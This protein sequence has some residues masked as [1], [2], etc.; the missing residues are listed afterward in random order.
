MTTEYLKNSGETTMLSK[1]ITNLFLSTRELLVN[2][3]LSLT[4]VHAEK[5][6]REGASSVL[7]ADLLAE[8]HLVPELCKL[9][10]GVPVLCEE[11][12]N[13]GLAKLAPDVTLL[14][15]SDNVNTLPQDAISVDGLDGS[16][17]Y[18]NG[19]LSL[20]AMSAGLIKD[21]QPHAGIIMM[22]DEGVLYHT[23]IN[24]TIGVFRADQSHESWREP[25]RP[26]KQ[27]LI[28]L[29]DNKAVE[30]TFRQFVVN[31][32][33]GSAGTQYPLNVPSVAGGIK[34]LQGKLAVY[35]TSNARHWDIAGTA[36]LCEGAGMV[37]RCL[38]GSPVPWN[39]VQMPPVVFARDEEAF[40][41]VHEQAAE[42]LEVKNERT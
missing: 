8:Q 23:G 11:A 12:E 30:T 27:S 28:G 37:V 5:Q 36:A 20:V 40:S 14:P 16:A 19:E 34:V 38:N 2:D 15:Y 3:R 6:L 42:Y 31:K 13:S 9:W 21:G 25:R 24:G 32:L 29:D 35:V 22:L 33:T 7:A 26:L 10:R 18:A 1:N 4:V 39:Q 17:L 41:Y